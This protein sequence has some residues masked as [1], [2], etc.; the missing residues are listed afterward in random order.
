MR[1]AQLLKNKLKVI[2]THRCIRERIEESNQEINNNR[3]IQCN[4]FPNLPI[5]TEPE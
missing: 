4:S 3:L 1:N 2:L 5:A